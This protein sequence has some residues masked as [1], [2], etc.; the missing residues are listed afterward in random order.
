MKNWLKSTHVRLCLQWMT[1]DFGYLKGSQLQLIIVHTQLHGSQLCIA[2]YNHSYIA[3]MLSIAI[4]LEAMYNL[5]TGYSQLAD[6][7]LSV[8]G[9][10]VDNLCM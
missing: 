3:S 5:A 10:M 8:L 2:T 9:F 1:M 7:L 6:L 4:L